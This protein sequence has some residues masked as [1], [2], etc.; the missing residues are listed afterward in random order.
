MKLAEII[1]QVPRFGE[2]IVDDNGV[3]TRKFIRYLEAIESTATTTT[4]EEIGQDVIGNLANFQSFIGRY[5]SDIRGI[6]AISDRADSAGQLGQLFAGLQKSISDLN[7]L[8]GLVMSQAG[9][10]F[11][12]ASM[13]REMQEPSVPAL[14]VAVANTDVKKAGSIIYV[15]NETGGATLAA[16]NGTNW[17]RCT[18]LTNIA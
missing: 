14:T 4:S 17:Q 18:D 16:S 3:P 6:E 15:T 8:A 7:D 10:E 2:A 5:N 12:I 13:R 11:M 9:Q 1:T